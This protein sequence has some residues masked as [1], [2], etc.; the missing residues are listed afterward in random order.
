[1]TIR[2][3]AKAEYDLASIADY[4]SQ[5]NPDAS[6]DYEEKFLHAFDLLIEQPRM[7]RKRSDIHPNLRSWPVPPY[8]LF[9]TAL[10]E[11]LVLVRVLHMAQSVTPDLFD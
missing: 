8:I 7:G 4:L 10:S 9:Y 6:L 3:T 2:R 5:R 11:D 1:M